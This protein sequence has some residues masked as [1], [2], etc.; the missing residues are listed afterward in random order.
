MASR[1]GKSARPRRACQM[2]GVG[3]LITRR[4]ERAAGAY[5]DTPRN[6]PLRSIQLS[7]HSAR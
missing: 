2:K 5:V 6:T 3:T 1:S 4:G 7:Q